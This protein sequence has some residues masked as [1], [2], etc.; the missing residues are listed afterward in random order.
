MD[1]NSQYSNIDTEPKVI[2]S[3]TT[4]PAAIKYAHRSILS[5]LKSKVR[6][7]KLILYVTESEFDDFKELNE[8]KR[9]SEIYP[10]FEVRNYPFN[11]RSYRKLIPALADFPNDIIIT[12][13]DDVD[14]HPDMIGSLITHHHKYPNAIFAHRAKRIEPNKPYKKW[15]KYRWYHFLFK[16]FY[17]SPLNIPTGVGGVLYPPNSL[18]KEFIDAELFT[19]IAPT[20]DDIWFWAAATA[21]GTEIMP[22]PFGYNKPK[23]LQKP[24]KLSLKTVNFKEGFDNNY[25]T[26]N[27]IVEL[28]PEISERIA[29]R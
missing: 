14:Y 1:H 22:V 12:V 18:K 4:F 6:P 5:L 11:I 15:K 8:I 29:T 27:K 28:Y 10:H 21:N 17:H 26:F 2:V 7:H 20:T 19:Q 9:L 23:G 16:K 24:K 13:D 3:M 25:Q